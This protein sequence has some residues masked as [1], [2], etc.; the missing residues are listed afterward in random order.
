MLA[1][2]EALTQPPSA[3]QV[4]YYAVILGTAAII[5]GV[6][7]ITKWVVSTNI[8]LYHS[9]GANDVITLH[10]VENSG[11][12]FGLFPQFQGLYLVVAAVVVLYI[13]FAGHQF[14]TTWSRQTVLGLILGGAVSNGIDRFT[15]G[16][17]VDFIDLHWWPVFNVADMAI[18]V[19]ILAA[20]FQV[21][22]RRASPRQSA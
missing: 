12:A 1:G 14:G 4:R 20:V 3:A 18:V 6:D 9:V 11:A 16:Y 13:L 17:V 10:H 5:I 8:P 7:H 2:S 21:G 19:G 22:W 15:Q